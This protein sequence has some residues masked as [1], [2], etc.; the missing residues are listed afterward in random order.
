MVLRNI[1]L[2]KGGLNS[3]NFKLFEPGAPST[4]GPALPSGRKRDIIDVMLE[5]KETVILLLFS[6]HF[7]WELL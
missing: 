1:S 7:F 2:R 4:K 6:F 3:F 5:R